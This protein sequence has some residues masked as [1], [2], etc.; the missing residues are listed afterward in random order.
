MCWYAFSLQMTGDLARG[1]Q[2]VHDSDIGISGENAKNVMLS[3]Q[4]RDV[5]KLIFPYS[6]RFEFLTNFAMLFCISLDVFL[7]I[8]I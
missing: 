2:E 4:H 7:L 5:D 6:N 1:I 3:P 8:A